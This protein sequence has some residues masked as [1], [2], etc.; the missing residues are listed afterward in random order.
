[1]FTYS[2]KCDAAKAREALGGDYAVVEL[3]GAVKVVESFVALYGGDMP[4]CMYKSWRLTYTDVE[5]YGL[6]K[7]EVLVRGD[8]VIVRLVRG[9]EKVGLP[10]MV[11]GSPLVVHAMDVNEGGVMYRVFR[12]GGY[13]ELAA[14][15]VANGVKEAFHPKKGV[16]I[17]IVDLPHMP[18][19]QHLLSE[20]FELAREHYVELHTTMISDVCPLC[21]GRME[22]RGR[23][24]YC[25][26]CKIQLNRDVNAVWALAR[27]IVRRL[28]RERQ[29]AELREIFRLY[30][31]NV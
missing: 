24:V 3:G 15:G 9:D 5:T 31:P 12:M 25:P 14:K 4:L 17:L 11:D 27:N 19:F 29:L 18:K 20:V 16:N 22:K 2:L 23:L 10:E 30:Y 1:V 26:Q 6:A 7:A 21:G 8:R 28:G 13:V